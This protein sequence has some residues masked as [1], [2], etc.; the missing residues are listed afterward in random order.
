MKETENEV[1]VNFQKIQEISL[2]IFEMAKE[3]MLAEQINEKIKIDKYKEQL[4]NLL[5]DVSFINEL[6]AKRLVSE[7]MLDLD[8]INEK[9]VRVLSMRLGQIY[10]VQEKIK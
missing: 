8:Y 3:K 7:A 1:D 6:E 4:V 5:K 2:K 9:E 10:R